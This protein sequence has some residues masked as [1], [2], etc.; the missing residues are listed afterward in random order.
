MKNSKVNPTQVCDHEPHPVVLMILPVRPV[1]ITR[2]KHTW[3]GHKYRPV[4]V[5]LRSLSP[6]VPSVPPPQTHSFS[7][8]NAFSLPAALLTPP[9]PHYNRTRPRVTRLFLHSSLPILSVCG[10]PARE[11]E[12]E[13][14]RAKYIAKD[15]GTSMRTPFL[16]SVHES[17]KTILGDFPIFIIWGPST[18]YTIV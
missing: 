18:E 4:R 8:Q 14:T 10:E 5:N 3:T 7:P 17:R 11:K 15:E 12:N 13:R 1:H 6:S 16:S 9:P 2:P